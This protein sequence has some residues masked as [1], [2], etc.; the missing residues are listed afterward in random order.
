MVS[1]IGQITLMSR[2]YLLVFEHTVTGQ[3]VWLLSEWIGMYVCNGGG[4]GDGVREVAKVLDRGHCGWT[5]ISR[6]SDTLLTQI[7]VKYTLT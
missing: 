4:S 7:Y 2:V 3:C 6:G 1:N 5:R